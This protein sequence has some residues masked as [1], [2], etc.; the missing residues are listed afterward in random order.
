MKP[1]ATT[2]GNSGDRHRRFGYRPVSQGCVLPLMLG[3]F[4]LWGGDTDSALPPFPLEAEGDIR[5]NEEPV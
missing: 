5:F 4:A 1:Q 2:G 3:A